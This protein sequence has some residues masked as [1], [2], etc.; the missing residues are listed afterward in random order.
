MSSGFG[1]SPEDFAIRA[2]VHDS[3]LFVSIKDYLKK[4]HFDNKVYG[5]LY[6]LLTKSYI[7][8][9]KL[10]SFDEMETEIDLTVMDKVRREELHALVQKLRNTEKVSKAYSRGVEKF[11]KNQMTKEVVSHVIRGYNK[12]E[13]PNY[14]KM[15]QMMERLN[16]KLV[17]DEYVVASDV[18][19]L[20]LGDAQVGSQ[21]VIPSAIPDL[22]MYLAAGG[23]KKRTVNLISAA[24]KTGK[25]TLLS[26]ETANAI[27]GRNF[28]PKKVLHV[29]IGDLTIEDGWYK[30]V[31]ALMNTHTQSE[32]MQMEASEVLE[33]MSDEHKKALKNLVIASY[34]SMT[35][36]ADTLYEKVMRMVDREFPDGVDMTVVDYID[37]L[38]YEGEG[39]YERGGKN[40]SVLEKISKDTDSA[41]LTGSQLKTKLWTN[42]IVTAVNTNAESSKK[43]AMIDLNL[44][45]GKK[46]K[47]PDNNALM[48]MTITLNRRGEDSIR[49]FLQMDYNYCFIKR[50]TETEWTGKRDDAKRRLKELTG[51]D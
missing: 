1:N 17:K 30:I 15:Q 27:S 3:S 25:S 20:V 37:N 23:Y 11:I 12:K 18:S 24:P 46:I 34:P 42:E 9:G 14:D 48:C 5:A 35:L 6:H 7:N 49:L 39:L 44:A 8:Y 32:I 41:V 50:L 45:L 2:I 22:N 47:L 28:E 40:F 10:L 51:E 29:L 33:V 19:K 26:I 38:I 13:A 43:E 21:N 36:T 31:S 4:N 16:F